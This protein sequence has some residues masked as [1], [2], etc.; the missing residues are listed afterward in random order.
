M[1]M[2]T[3]NDLQTGEKLY[4]IYSVGVRWSEGYPPGAEWRMHRVGVPPL[5]AGRFWNSTGWERMEQDDRP[6]VNL[7]TEIRE[8][9]WPGYCQTKKLLKPADL[10]VTVRLNRREVWCDGW[11]SHYSFDV[12]MSDQEV[13]A[14]FARYVER[15]LYS[16]RPE[17]EIGGR[18]MGAEDRW[19][20]H[21]CVSPDPQAERTEPPCRCP[22]C[23]A[24]GLVRIDH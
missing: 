8:Q 1:S 9:W 4:P 19:R 11:F 22:G 3:E 17:N 7:A 12:G 16:G 18:L 10:L 23:K 5:P 14:S 21:G 20:W 6:A 2:M 13:L 24:A 15:V